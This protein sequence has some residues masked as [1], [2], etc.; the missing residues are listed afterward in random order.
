MAITNQKP[1]T[2]GLLLNSKGSLKANFLYN[3][4]MKST[5]NMM[6][7]IKLYTNYLNSAFVALYCL[8][9]VHKPQ[10]LKVWFPIS[11]V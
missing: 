5:W 4:T 1:Q 9:F 7:F 2:P 10:F 8:L 3:I 6:I 11:E